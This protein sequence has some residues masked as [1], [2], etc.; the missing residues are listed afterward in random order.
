MSIES[1][2]PPTD[3]TAD[4]TGQLSLQAVYLKDCSFE[5]P[6]GPRISPFHV[7]G[8]HAISVCRVVGCALALAGACSS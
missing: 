1:P 2:Q 6:Q 7:H 5:A 4:A 8:I 3:S